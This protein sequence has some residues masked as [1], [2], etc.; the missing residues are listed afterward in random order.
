MSLASILADHCYYK[1]PPVRCKD[2]YVGAP[3]RESSARLRKGANG[4][5][6]TVLKKKKK[7]QGGKGGEELKVNGETSTGGIGGVKP[8]ITE[9]TV[10]DGATFMGLMERH[11][12]ESKHEW[13]VYGHVAAIINTP[14]DQNSNALDK[15]SV[16]ITSTQT[17]KAGDSRTEL[18][19]SDAASKS[20]PVPAGEVKFVDM[21]DLDHQFNNPDDTALYSVVVPEW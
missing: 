6:L 1:E 16:P 12:L 11:L 14:T 10:P 8:E 15:S 19:G 9:I 5:M 4:H 2:K 20:P 3:K 7:K 13:K 17:Q 21:N 18:K